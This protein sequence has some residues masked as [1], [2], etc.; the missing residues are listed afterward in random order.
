MCVTLLSL[1]LLLYADIFNYLLK[2]STLISS[3]NLKCFMFKKRLSWPKLYLPLVLPIWNNGILISSGQIPSN[4]P[5]FLSFFLSHFVNDPDSEALWIFP[6]PMS[7]MG[8]IPRYF[9][10]TRLVQIAY[11]PKWSPCL[12][13][14][15]TWLSS[16]WVFFKT[17]NL[18]CHC[19]FQSLSYLK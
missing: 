6:H 5:N 15:P 10:T 1:F 13:F 2:I 11:S 12:H 4:Y 19:P 8:E 9:V 3:R 16:F 18:K 14:C 17:I 7:W